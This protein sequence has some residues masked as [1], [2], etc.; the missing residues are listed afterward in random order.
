MARVQ[1]IG[2]Q[3]NQIIKAHNGIGQSKMQ[4]RATSGL[5]GQN[6][7]NISDKFHSYKSLDNARRE[8]T[9]LGKFAKKEFGIKDMS[10]ITKEVVKE[11]IK[12]KDI[13]YKTA[14]NY[15]SNIYK[16]ADHFTIQR[17]EIKEIREELK[18]A[19][20]K[21][22]PLAKETRAYKDLDKITLPTPQ[23]NLAFK[24]QRDYGLRVKEATHI[25]LNRQLQDNILQVQGKGGK[26]IYKELDEG[27]V[28]EIK[29]LANKDGIFKVSPRTYAYQLQKEIEKTGQTYNGTHGIRHS[30]AQS[31]LEEGYTKQ[32]VS[33][34]M[35]H[36][37]EE[38]TN[39]YL[40]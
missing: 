24:L 18:Q 15:L 5:K 9:D 31:K 10:N 23:T 32:E 21:T 16:V 28:K 7:H 29:E 19:I 25:N 6:N 35:G 3:V 36:N 12:S 20:N 4:T 14:S 27:L 38:I 8:L 26:I 30:Y 11:W 34:M 39:T 33:E 2:Y 17:S 22:P 37:R 13:T 1:A 40:R